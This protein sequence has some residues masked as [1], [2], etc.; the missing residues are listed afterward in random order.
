MR[1]FLNAIFFTF[2]VFLVQINIIHADEPSIK[3]EEISEK[4]ASGSESASETPIATEAT[5]E[6]ESDD[7]VDLA[8]LTDEE[9]EEICTSR[10]FEVVKEKDEETGEFKKYSHEDYIN[11]ANQC[12]DMEAEMEAILNENPELIKE[13]EAE[14]ERMRQENE[15][16]EN[17]IKNMINDNIDED[18]TDDE[19]VDKTD[20][21]NESETEA[22]EESSTDGETTTMDNGNVV[23]E[24]DSDEVLDLDSGK[25]YEPTKD[26]STD[27][28]VEEIPT[29]DISFMSITREVKDQMIKDFNRVADL[30]LPP[31]L[32][33]P[34]K[35]AL[36]PIVQ[37]VKG[38]LST[39]VD[40]VKRYT[41]QIFE[42]RKNEGN[43]QATK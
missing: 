32:R 4:V 8:S 1:F 43:E 13:I 23:I 38:A 2:L 39:T 19:Q 34:L 14:A 21:S 20:D 6:A 41:K 11:A 35:K 10:G 40:M 7:E 16:L 18:Q 37:I 42:Q 26:T 25:S 31:Q 15:R 28:S 12:L 29:E 24:E 5:A 30:L 33:G 27:I 22:A 9:L 17:E 3:G 36:E